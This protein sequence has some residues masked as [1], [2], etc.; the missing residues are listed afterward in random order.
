MRIGLKPGVYEKRVS[1]LMTKTK[2]PMMDI[3]VWG[4]WAHFVK[5]AL[6]LNGQGWTIRAGKMTLALE[7]GE[8]VGDAWLYFWLTGDVSRMIQP[9]E[10]DLDALVDEFEARPLAEVAS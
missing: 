4:N 3:L 10:T 1:A 8:V 6:H 5:P 9:A 2:L 7:D